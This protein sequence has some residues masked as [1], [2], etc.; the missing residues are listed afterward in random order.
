MFMLWLGPICPELLAK[1]DI[2]VPISAVSTSS[3]SEQSSQA[4][5]SRWYCRNRWE[6]RS[7]PNFTRR[8]VHSFG[9]PFF[10]SPAAGPMVLSAAADGRVIRRLAD[11]L[12][13]SPLQ[14]TERG[15]LFIVKQIYGCYNGDS[16]IGIISIRST[17]YLILLFLIK[18]YER[19][20]I[21][22]FPSLYNIFKSL[23]RDIGL[24]Y[25]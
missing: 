11:N 16:L 14:E 8:D 19:S 7:V 17:Q 2:Q 15:F 4:R 24:L 25:F 18:L 13:Q 23:I 20:Y 3:H 10:V 5:Q 21:S 12:I 1:K 22:V 9:R 6:S